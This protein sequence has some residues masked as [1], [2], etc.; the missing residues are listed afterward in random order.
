MNDVLLQASNLGKYYTYPLNLTYQLGTNVA[1]THMHRGDVDQQ[2]LV[3]I[4]G[5]V[6]PLVVPES[7]QAPQRN[8]H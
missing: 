5:K 4:A 3:R 6:Q 2:L 7:L 1:T 8:R